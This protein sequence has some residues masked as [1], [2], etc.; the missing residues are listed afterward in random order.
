M[1]GLANPTYSYSLQGLRPRASAG[2]SCLCN[3][4]MVTMETVEGEL[5]SVSLF[6]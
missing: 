5:Q 1:Y 4:S 3:V 6:G 2:T